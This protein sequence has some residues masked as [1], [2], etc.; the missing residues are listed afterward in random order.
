MM[1]ELRLRGHRIK[2]FEWK[3]IEVSIK[4]SFE[5]TDKLKD[6]LEQI[7]LHDGSAP[8]SILGYY[9]DNIDDYCSIFCP[10]GYKPY[11]EIGHEMRANSR[12]FEAAIETG[13]VCDAI[14]T[15]IGA[16]LDV[17]ENWDC[18]KPGILKIVNDPIL[19]VHIEC[20]D[21]VFIEA[22]KDVEDE[23]ED[24][25]YST[26]DRIKESLP[27]SAFKGYC[28]EVLLMWVLSVG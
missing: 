15:H 11:E 17:W 4:S 25:W 13:L 24:T 14:H 20:R 16:A 27:Q 28:Y 9:L 22:L 8:A 19:K 10:L 5:D 26:V 1:K 3:D 12:V 7:M 21:R 23:D 18:M 2:D 6:V